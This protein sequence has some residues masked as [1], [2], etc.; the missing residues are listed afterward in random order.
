MLGVLPGG[1]AVSR[2]IDPH[3]PLATRPRPSWHTHPP[4]SPTVEAP[5][6]QRRE[7]RPTTVEIALSPEG[8]ALLQGL[9]AERR[10]SESE[11]VEW[12]LRLLRGREGGEP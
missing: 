9:A 1:P 7:Q 8:M 3:W 5:W 12:A 6:S 4:E 2:F 10:C 11:A